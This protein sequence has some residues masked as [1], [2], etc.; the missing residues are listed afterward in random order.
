MPLEC[1]PLFRTDEQGSALDKYKAWLH[2]A[3]LTMIVLTHHGPVPGYVIRSI[4]SY[5]FQES[6]HAVVAYDGEVVWDP[7]PVRDEAP[8]DAYSTWTRHWLIL[9]RD[10]M[11][12]IAL[13]ALVMS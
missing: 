4:L 8:P 2:P 13:D 1:V 3:N 12:R 5:R 9:P 7:S 11:Q 10:P 6:Q